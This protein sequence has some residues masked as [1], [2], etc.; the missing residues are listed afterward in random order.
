MC[1][2]IDIIY[3]LYKTVWSARVLRISPENLVFF[4]RG[5]ITVMGSNARKRTA[6]SKARSKKT[7]SI[8]NQQRRL[9][10][11]YHSKHNIIL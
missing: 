10:K 11:K 3:R 7:A 8:S 6:V 2:H 9:A 4:R 5:V 1:S